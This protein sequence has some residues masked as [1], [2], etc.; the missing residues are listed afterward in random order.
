MNVLLII[1][2][3]SDIIIYCC[4]YFYRFLDDKLTKDIF[5]IAKR[6]AFTQ[7]QVLTKQYKR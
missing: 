2:M 1:V 6:S 4:I 7:M 5:T 3:L